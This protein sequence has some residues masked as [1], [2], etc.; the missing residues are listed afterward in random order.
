MPG[1]CWAAE[2]MLLALADGSAILPLPGWHLP[3]QNLRAGFQS[4]RSGKL[5]VVDCC[6]SP[7]DWSHILFRTVAFRTLELLWSSSDGIIQV[8]WQP[9]VFLYLISSTMNS[10]GKK[11]GGHKAH[12]SLTFTADQYRVSFAI[13]YVFCLAIFVYFNKYSFVPTWLLPVA[14]KVAKW[15]MPWQSGS[16]IL[17]FICQQH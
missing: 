16:L 8:F 3:W 15:Q 1:A 10:D 7:S 2:L 5:A 14:R 4:G 6:T 11:K 17:K 12:P 13:F 9:K